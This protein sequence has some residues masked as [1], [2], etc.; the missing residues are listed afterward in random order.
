[1]EDE[2]DDEQIDDQAAARHGS[3]R[4]SDDDQAA[5]SVDDHEDDQPQ[6]DSDDLYAKLKP[7]QQRAILALITEPTVAKA[8]ESAGVSESTVHRWLLDDT[9]AKAFR[10]ARRETFGQAIALAQRYTPLAVN[11]LAKIMNDLATAASAR[12]SAACAI[13]KF[14]RDS[15]ELDDLQARIESLETAA[16]QQEKWSRR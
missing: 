13:L 2:H 16:A 6:P 4:S 5:A 12:V 15:I 1:M 14:A 3:A 8:A 7:K 10:R 11:N 9:F